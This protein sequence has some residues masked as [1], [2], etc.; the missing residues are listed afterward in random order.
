MCMMTGFEESNTKKVVGWIISRST[1]AFMI[2]Y[3]NKYIILF[4]ASVVSLDIHAD[5]VISVVS[6]DQ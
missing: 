5:A 4:P 6:T 2:M 3:M 1:Q